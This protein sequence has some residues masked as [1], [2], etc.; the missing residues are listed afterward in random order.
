MKTKVVTENTSKFFRYLIENEKPY[1]TSQ[2]AEDFMPNSSKAYV[3]S[4]LQGLVQRELTYRLKKGLYMLMPYYIKEEEF[5]PNP[6]LT[7][8]ALAGT[9]EHYIAYLSALQVHELISS[10]SLKQHLVVKQQISPNKANIKGMEYQYICHNEKLFFGCENL[11]VEYLN[12]VYPI[13][14]SNLEKTLLDSIYRPQY[15]GG[16]QQVATALK[17]AC[18]RIDYLKLIDYVKRIGSQ[19]IIKRL[20]YLLEI[21][22]IENPIIGELK[23]MKTESYIRLDPTYEKKGKTTQK[24]N[25]QINVSPQVIHE[26]SL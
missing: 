5:F 6:Y 22:N 19:S 10:A 9:T 15:I 26:I 18:H 7:A 24:W 1:F 16:I 17:V 21:L 8:K 14:T 4:F 23:R 2:D 3:Q 25:I 11:W 13:C 12:H 20:G